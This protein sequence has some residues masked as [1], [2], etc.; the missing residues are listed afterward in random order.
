MINY[1]LFLILI[2]NLF[3]INI[4]SFYFNIL[5]YIHVEYTDCYEIL[6]KS[7]KK[8]KKRYSCEV[9]TCYLIFLFLL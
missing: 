7:F 4:I 5:V 1:I 9:K 3:I 2:N 8:Y 6:L